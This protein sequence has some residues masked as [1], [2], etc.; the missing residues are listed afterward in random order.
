VKLELEL[1]STLETAAGP[2]EV[3]FRRWVEAALAG[4]KEEVELVIR[5]VDEAES[6]EL[7]NRYRG[8]DAPTNVLSFPA[9][10]PEVVETTLLGDLVIAVPVVEREAEQQGK[11]VEAHWAHLVV[12][13][14]LHLLDYTHREEQDAA[15]MEGL[16]QGIMA[17]LGFPDPY[18]ESAD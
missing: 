6:R 9:S 8:I 10:L 7:N 16:E 3:D 1:Q 15:I 5:L 18:A 12:H 4:R 17:G 13:G 11:Q 14:V 2:S